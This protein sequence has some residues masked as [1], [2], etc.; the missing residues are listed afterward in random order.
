M[1]VFELIEK[2][3]N[4]PNEFRYCDVILQKDSEGNGYSPLVDIDADAIYN[5]DT[6]YSGEVFSTE[7]SAED[8]G[9][10]SEEEWEEYKRS[11]KRAVVLFPVN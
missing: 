2:L 9:F 8:A 7:W 4:L 6:T 10:D 11:H 1:K 5:P 3:T